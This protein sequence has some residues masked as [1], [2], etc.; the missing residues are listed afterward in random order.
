MVLE[1]LQMNDL[2][3]C[4]A[5]R[6]G[7][8]LYFLVFTAAVHARCCRVSEVLYLPT[9]G[10]RGVDDWQDSLWCG[11]TNRCVFP[12]WRKLGFSSSLYYND[13]QGVSVDDWK[14]SLWCRLSDRCVLPVRGKLGFSSSVYYAWRNLVGG[15]DKGKKVSV[16]ISKHVNSWNWVFARFSGFLQLRLFLWSLNEHLTVSTWFFQVT[17]TSYGYD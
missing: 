4:G 8:W 6:S 2:R 14:R 13:S 5:V 11:W 7:G 12:V 10:S 1:C 16:V 17:L 3:L 9:S 15:Q